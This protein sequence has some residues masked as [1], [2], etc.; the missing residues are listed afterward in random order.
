MPPPDDRSALRDIELACELIETFVADFSREAFLADART[1]S[2]VELQLITIGEA[3]KRLSM[4]LRDAAPQVDWRGWAGTRDIIVH[5][6]DVVDLDQ[7]WFIATL[8]VPELLAA[9]RKLLDELV[10]GGAPARATGSTARRCAT[11]TR[12]P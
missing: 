10:D 5:A 3:V 11:P 12:T 7:V 4:A 1:F 2:A 6:Y 8:E 9:T